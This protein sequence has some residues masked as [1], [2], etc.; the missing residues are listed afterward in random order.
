MGVLVEVLPFYLGGGGGG[1]GGGGALTSYVFS[2]LVLYTDLGS[3]GVF[4][5]STSLRWNSAEILRNNIWSK[6]D[7]E[8]HRYLGEFWK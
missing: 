7:N 2:I 8:N 6:L 3:Q 1:G 5:R 4:G